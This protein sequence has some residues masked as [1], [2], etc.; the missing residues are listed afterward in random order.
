M[1]QAIPYPYQTIP[2]FFGTDS[3]TSLLFLFLRGVY[4]MTHLLVCQFGLRFFP[5]GFSSL[6]CFQLVWMSPCRDCHAYSS[7]SCWNPLL[8]RVLVLELWPFGQNN[9]VKGKLLVIKKPLF[10]TPT[11]YR[12]STVHLAWVFKKSQSLGAVDVMLFRIQI[13]MFECINVISGEDT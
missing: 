3:H 6:S 12:C 7:G 8:W 4:R 9:P 1:Y 5:D 13:V 10:K 2:T 11:R